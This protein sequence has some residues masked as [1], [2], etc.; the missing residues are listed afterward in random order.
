MHLE[1]IFRMESAWTLASAAL[2]RQKLEWIDRA[3]RNPLFQKLLSTLM[4]PFAFFFTS[5]R[6]QLNAL[7]RFLRYNPRGPLARFAY[8][9]AIELSSAAEL[10]EGGQTLERSIVLKQ[11]GPNGELGYL[12][13]HF[14]SELT[15]L[16]RLPRLKEL[17]Q[18]FDIVFQS[19][20]HP[21]YCPALYAFIA[22]GQPEAAAH[23]LLEARLRIVPGLAHGLGGTTFPGFPAG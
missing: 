23:A 7:D 9:K 21:F 13:V 14:E 8:R 22:A 6:H 11:P 3:K 12:L 17:Q 16:A 15:K 10:V 5:T 4:L 1:C 19:T 18:Q 2:K 20:W